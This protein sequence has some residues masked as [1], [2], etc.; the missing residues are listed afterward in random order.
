MDKQV[1]GISLREPQNNKERAIIGL[2][3]EKAKELCYGTLTLDIRYHN[4][5]LTN[6]QI[7][8]QK[9]SINLHNI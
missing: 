6:I 8:E 7:I 3:Q 5:E 2:I 9:K 4:G 1:N